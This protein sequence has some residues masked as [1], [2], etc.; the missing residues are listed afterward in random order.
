MAAEAAQKR[1]DQ[2]KAEKAQLEAKKAQLEAKLG[3][4]ELVH[5]YVK[6]GKANF[7]ATP[8]GNIMGT[9]FRGMELGVSEEDSSG[10]WVQATIVGWI[11]K[12]STGTDSTHKVRY[13]S[14]EKENF[15]ATP[16]GKNI[17]KLLK[18]S[19]LAVLQERGNWI[20]VTVE[21]WIWRKLTSTRKPPVMSKPPVISKPLVTEKQPPYEI[22]SRS[23]IPGQINLSIVVQGEP[24]KDKLKELVYYLKKHYSV[25]RKH[26]FS[27]YKDTVVGHRLARDEFYDPP[28]PQLKENWLLLYYTEDGF[29]WEPW[30]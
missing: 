8:K 29:S 25:Y 28:L 4:G 2:L 20:Q 10:K 27:I 15:R 9:I 26:C 6:A 22:V 24:G 23:V 18:G 3:L 1:L 13:V 14:V 11:W 17:G 16:N 19:R 21:G 7:R 12:A 30:Q 5:R